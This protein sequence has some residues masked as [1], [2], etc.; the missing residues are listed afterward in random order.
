MIQ[1]KERDRD[2]LREREREIDS[3]I[4]GERDRDILR[5]R[6]IES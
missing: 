5:K 2:I 6:V 1:E 4:L 3:Y